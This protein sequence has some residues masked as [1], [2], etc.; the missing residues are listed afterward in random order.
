[1]TA[2][3]TRLSVKTSMVTLLLTEKGGEAKQLDFDKDEVTIGRVQGNDVV[4]PKGN[5]SKR[6]C[7]ILAHAGRFSVEDL[8]STNG[9][10]INGRKIAEATNVSGS[11]KIYVG[12]FVIKVENAGAETGLSSPAPEAGSLSTA[13]PR[14][15]PPPPAPG[16]ATSA[17]RALDDDQ[18]ADARARGGN[19]GS[20]P[21]PPPRR[22]PTPAPPT[23][24]SSGVDGLADLDLAPPPAA[25]ADLDLDDDEVL[26]PRR[27]AVP[28]LKSARPLSSDEPDE[29]SADLRPEPRNTHRERAAVA[30][31][32]PSLRAG[33]GA[34]PA[35]ADALANWLRDML[36]TDGAT[37]IY[38]NGAYL[39]IER[40][41]RREPV[42][43]PAGASLQDAVRSLASRG[44]PRPAGDTRVINVM[45]PENA[46]LAAIFPPVASDLSL[47][48]QKLAPAGRSLEALAD[49]GAL[50]N[51]ARELL[52]ACVATRRNILIG[53]D[54]R[55]LDVL[56]EA[57]ARA[58]P[59]RLRVVS[60]A[61]ALPAAE[62]AGWIKLATD[63]RVSDIVMA[64]ASLRPDYLVVEV[65]APPLATDVLSQCVL[66]QEGT[67]VAVAARSAADALQRLAALA[68]PAL[69]GIAHAREL[70]AT[71][72]DLVLCAGTLADGTVRLLELGEPRVEGTG[73]LTVDPIVSFAANG[74]GGSGHFEVTA[75][76]SRLASTLGARGVQLP[77]G[78]FR[79]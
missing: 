47:T 11:D 37:A 2:L 74:H 46:R 39:E 42:D 3:I 55:A 5:V 25:S 66:G 73:G 10:Y 22:D 69:G 56:L 61:A 59:P 34:P 28:P 72:F 77:A 38:V 16:R 54:G 17:M 48:L 36:T 57:V 76:A 15:P 68:G 18:V 23:G 45:L 26:A 51:E 6:H 60:L 43:L 33:A 70:A 13:V 53:G 44:S 1:L 64:A 14:R 67:I 40:N 58:I 50:P 79:A 7:R 9:T 32:G 78:L 65:T 52:E 75:G 63:T 71:A 30:A 29:D 35:S 21:P 24:G 41:G 8:K 20:L 49:G 31:G 62:G 4:L 12:D 19:R 27:L